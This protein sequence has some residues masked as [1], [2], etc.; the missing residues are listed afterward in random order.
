MGEVRGESA[1]PPQAG[2]EAEPTEA[3]FVRRLVPVRDGRMSVLLAGPET[4]P[5]LVFC[6]A[7]GF[8]ALTYRTLLAPLASTVRLVVPDLRGHGLG[9][10]PAVPAR[11]RSWD[12]YARDLGA[13][14]DALKV[15]RA[16]LAGHSMGGVTA[17]LAGAERRERVAGLVLLDPVI[18]PRPFYWA[19]LLP[20]AGHLK[21]SAH[22]MVTQAAR[23]RAEFASRE[24]AVAAYRGRGAFARWP[25]EVLA[26]YVRGGTIPA[27]AGD[28]DG[29]KVR[30]ACAP[31]WEAA[32]FAAHAHYPWAAIARLRVP[33]TILAAGEGS[34]FP[35]IVASAVASLR[36][37]WRIERL[38]DTRHLFPMEEPELARTLIAR[39]LDG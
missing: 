39:A 18:L 26:D 38:D 24:D 22:P 23:R 27:G 30:L 28:A 1:P 25:D 20:G 2:A 4:G 15:E 9:D 11:L 34:T 8:N 16:V 5:T 32:T 36:P 21:R 6:H 7:T 17:L 19:Q 12:T 35:P 29:G 37:Q 33:A 31:A 3:P 13:L 10:L 14:L